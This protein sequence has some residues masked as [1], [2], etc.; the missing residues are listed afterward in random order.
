MVY[1]GKRIDVVKNRLFLVK[2]KIKNITEIIGLE[3]LTNLE[4][5]NLN[6]N[7]IIEIESLENLINLKMLRL[8]NNQITEIN[9]LDALTNLE[10]LFLDGNQIT[11]IKGLESLINLEYL[12]LSKNQI[13]EIS[14]LQN[15]VNL[16]GLCLKNNPISEKLLNKLGGLNKDGWINPKNILKYY[17]REEKL[18]LER[19][20]RFAKEKEILEKIRKIMNVST[21]LNLEMMR[22]ALSMDKKAFDV[23]VFDWASEFGFEIHGDYIEIKKE[24]VS[25]FID[26]LEKQYIEWSRKEETRTGKQI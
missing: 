19:Q 17:Q 7:Q 2:K 25:D 4:T 8:E 9:G 13:T 6:N 10:W 22:N 3:D 14:G 15:L 5:L 11:E 1:K 20:K 16:K 21:R 24:N 12:D 23:K 18:D 26:A